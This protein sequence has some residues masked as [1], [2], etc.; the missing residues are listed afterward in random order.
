MDWWPD[1]T[2]FKPPPEVGVQRVG[3]VNVDGKGPPSPEGV[4]GMQVPHEK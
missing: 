4:A 1:C 2:R 3:G